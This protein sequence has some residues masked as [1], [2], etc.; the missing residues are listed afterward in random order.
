MVN[1]EKI[2]KD[3]SDL[4]ILEAAEL[5]ENLEKKWNIKAALPSITQTNTDDTTTKK[6]TEKEKFD[7]ILVSPGTKKIQVIKTL[8]EIT[9]L[10]LKEAK[11]LADQSPKEIKKN[12]NKAEANI[13]KEKL[14]K[15]GATIELK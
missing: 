7:V 5:V 6:S 9:S 8:R 12:I 13:I 10:G 2:S 1:I 3:L 11:Q 15:S 4:T 14:E